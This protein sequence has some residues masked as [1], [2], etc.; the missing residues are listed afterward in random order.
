MVREGVPRIRHEPSDVSHAVRECGVR[1]HRNG[2]ERSG[3]ASDA[4]TPV[5]LPA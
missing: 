2:L 4:A 3:A 5:T 1:A